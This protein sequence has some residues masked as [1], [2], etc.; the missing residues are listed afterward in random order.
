MRFEQ[1]HENPKS[2]ILE[3]HLG[4]GSEFSSPLNLNSGAVQVRER[5]G[6]GSEPHPGNTMSEAGVRFG[7]GSM[8]AERLEEEEEVVERD[9][10][11]SFPNSLHLKYYFT[12]FRGC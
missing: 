11:G 8:T 10:G 2:S 12:D 1:V 9:P 4:F 7:T 3:P 5:F 6:S